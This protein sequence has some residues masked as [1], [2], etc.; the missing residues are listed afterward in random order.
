[1]HIQF[2]HITEGS[3]AIPVL[4]EIP[5]TAFDIPPGTLPKEWPNLVQRQFDELAQRNPNMRPILVFSTTIGD[6]PG[7]VVASEI[8]TAAPHAPAVTSEA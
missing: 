2:F 5:D 8:I 4:Q 7:S 3:L 1:M 6:P